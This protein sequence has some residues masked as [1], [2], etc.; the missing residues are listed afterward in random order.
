MR[1]KRKVG[2]EFLL[3]AIITVPFLAC[4]QNQGNGKKPPRVVF[5]SKE[6]D[7]GR[8]DGRR[9]AK[10]SWFEESGAWT[11]MWMMSEDY[12]KGYEQGWIEGRAEV[13]SKSKDKENR[14]S[15]QQPTATTEES[16][17]PQ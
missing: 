3:A 5:S 6:F 17:T 11:W 1:R 15:R 14:E 9:D 8:E 10:A 2:V 12:G 4:S 7:R 13:K 16:W